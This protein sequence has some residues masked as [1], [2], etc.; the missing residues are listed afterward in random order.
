MNRSVASLLFFA[1]AVLSGGCSS[2]SDSFGESASSGSSGSTGS[3]GGSVMPTNTD[4]AAF[5]RAGIADSESADARTVND[6]NFVSDENPDAF[7]DVF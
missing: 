4:L 2:H 3:S 5:V 6:V 7:N 1:A